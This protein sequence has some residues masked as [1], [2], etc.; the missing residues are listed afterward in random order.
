MVSFFQWTQTWYKKIYCPLKNYIVFIELIHAKKQQEC[1]IKRTGKYQIGGNEVILNSQE[2]SYICYVDYSIP[3]VDEAENK[4]K[5]NQKRFT[6]V[7]E[8]V[9]CLHLIHNNILFSF[10]FNGIYETLFIA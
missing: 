2:K 3:I 10:L 4:Q 9:K 7:S 1:F 8:S 6:I 5:F